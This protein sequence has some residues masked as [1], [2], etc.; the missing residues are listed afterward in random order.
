[1]RFTCRR[2][3]IAVV[4]RPL[5][6]LEQS[7]HGCALVGRILFVLASIFSGYDLRIGDGPRPKTRGDGGERTVGTRALPRSCIAIPSS[8]TAVVGVP[9]RGQAMPVRRCAACR[10]HRTYVRILSRG[11]ARWMRF[12]FRIH[13]QGLIPARRSGVGVAMKWCER[14]RHTPRGRGPPARD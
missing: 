11:S 7:A 8:T 5:R 12:D 3:R 4:N 13:F 10:Y 6:L 14:N 1:M 2:S 9:A